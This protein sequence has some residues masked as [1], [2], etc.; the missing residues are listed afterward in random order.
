MSKTVTKHI[1]TFD[2]DRGAILQGLLTVLRAA[3]PQGLQG[4]IRGGR[5]RMYEGY[6]DAD[7]VLGNEVLRALGLSRQAYAEGVGIN[8]D[9]QGGVS[10]VVD[11]TNHDTI[12]ALQHTLPAMIAAGLQWS[13][14]EQVARQHQGKVAVPDFD[15][16]TGQVKVRVLAGA[17]AQT[18]EDTEGGFRW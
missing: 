18:T 2:A 17:A 13:S 7:I 8:V 16:N 3:V 14:V 11:H 15:W 10:L 1:T 9:E 4:S 5:V 12:R 6:Q